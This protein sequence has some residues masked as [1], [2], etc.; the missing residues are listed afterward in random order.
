MDPF[1]QLVMMLFH[2][3]TNAHLQHFQTKSYAAHKAL[4]EYYDGII[5]LV[6]DLV[7]AYQGMHGVQDS[8]EA[9]FMI[10]TD[11]VDMLSSIREWI[12][13]NRTE[14]CPESHIQN[15]IDEIQTLIDSTLYKLKELS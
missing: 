8:Y 12:A 14:V 13:E 15:I 11:S 9:D 6:D 2:S 1:H 4:N 3:R 7:E 10:E 5:G